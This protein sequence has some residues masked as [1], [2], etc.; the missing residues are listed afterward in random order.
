MFKTLSLL[1]LVSGLFIGPIYWVYMV[2]F[3]GK[4]AQTIDLRPGAQPGEWVSSEFQLTPEMGPVGLLLLAS[5]SFAPNMDENKPPKDAYA[6]SVFHGEQAGPP[7]RF[8]FD[9]GSV[10][11][12]NPRFRERLLLL[13]QPQAGGYRVELAAAAPPD[14][15]L[16]SVQLEI[17][18]EV[19]EPDNRLVAAGILLL[20]MGLLG[21]L[22]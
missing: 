20:A 10:G 4:A 15:Q 16:D 5:G 17:R 1:L 21:L 11:N 12:T 13:K 9:A 2:Y 22:I 14:I 19:R 18:S 8:Q 7:I 3:T 6:A